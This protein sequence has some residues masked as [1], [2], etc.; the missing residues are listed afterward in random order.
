MSAA[1]DLAPP[2]ATITLRDPEGANHASPDLSADLIGALARA[3]GS[4]DIRVVVLAGSESVFCAGLTAGMLLADDQRQRIE[5]GRE[6]LRAVANCPV[7]VVAAAQGHAIGLGL[8]LALTADVTVLSE[9]SHYAVNALTYGL[10]P[11][12]GATYLLPARLGT[13]LGTEMLYTGRP[14]QGRELADRGCGVLVAPHDQ[15]AAKATAIAARMA[16]A[17]RSTLEALKGQLPGA[18]L[19][20]AAHERET[21]GHLVSATDPAVRS[22]IRLLHPQAAS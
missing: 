8:L 15:V 16:R 17:P 18:A 2:L 13:A 21:A 3:A 6:L 20:E 19:A 12:N 9:R 7:P 22:Q 11:C 14:Y 5:D 4:P 10:T 1:L